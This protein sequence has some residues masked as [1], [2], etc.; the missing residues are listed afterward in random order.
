MPMDITKRFK[1]AVKQV[2]ESL[3]IYPGGGPEV[4]IV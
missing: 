4:E 3:G 2:C 1:I